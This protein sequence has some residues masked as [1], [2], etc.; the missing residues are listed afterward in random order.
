MMAQLL[1]LG[2]SMSTIVICASHNEGK[3]EEISEFLK[4]L[5]ITLK[6]Q[7]AYNIEPAIE[8]GLT[9]LENALIKARHASKNSGHAAIADDSGLVIPALDGEPG[10]LSARYAGEDSNFQKNIAL[11]LKKLSMLKQRPPYHA[12]FICALVYLRIW[13]DPLPIWAIGE[14][15]GNICEEKGQ[16]G[17]GYDPIFFD[18]IQKC[19]A[20]EMSSDLK[21]EISHRGLAMKILL[22]KLKEELKP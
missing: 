20:A 12:K 14:W 7:S 18:P 8:D 21:N 19:T 11:V 9:F 1:Y 3:I 13:N 4:P 17:F 6:P 15:N 22:S 2:V 10:L 16:H 5:P